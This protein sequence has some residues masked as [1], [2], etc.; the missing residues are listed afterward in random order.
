MDRHLVR[1]YRTSGA[2]LLLNTNVKL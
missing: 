2:A 1:F